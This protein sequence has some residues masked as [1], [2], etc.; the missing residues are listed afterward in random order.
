M[1]IH[2]H[3]STPVHSGGIGPVQL[4]TASEH[5]EIHARR[6]LSGEDKMFHGNLYQFLLDE[7]LVKAVKNKLSEYQRKNWEDGT[8]P[9]HPSIRPDL[10]R[11]N[12]KISGKNA[13]ENGQLAKARKKC[14]FGRQSRIILT[15][16]Q[17]SEVLC[18]IQRKFAAEFLGVS[19]SAINKSVK[20]E[21]LIKGVWGARKG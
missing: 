4:V 2:K 11:N 8:H 13:V 10:L 12:G 17:T 1:P 21:H 18:F 5:A 19:P 20:R 6:Y 15:N 14:N 9:W 16:V 3:H 7:T